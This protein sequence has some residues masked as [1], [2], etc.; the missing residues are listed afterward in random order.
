MGFLLGV[1]FFF[2]FFLLWDN[3]LVFFIILYFFCFFYLF[4][5]LHFLLCDIFWHFLLWDI[6]LGFF[7][8]VYFFGIF[9]LGFYYPIKETWTDIIQ[10]CQERIKASIEESIKEFQQKISFYKTW[11]HHQTRPKR[12]QERIESSELWDEV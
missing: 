1:F 3:F 7:I 2:C 4:F 10:N 9:Y 5:F 11:K 6:F 12:V 8:T